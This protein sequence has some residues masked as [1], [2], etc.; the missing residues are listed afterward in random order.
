MNSIN[1][2]NSDNELITQTAH[3]SGVN[4]REITKLY[5]KLREKGLD[6][7]TII[8]NI[9]CEEIKDFGNIGISNPE[10][11][12]RLGISETDFPES[13]NINKYEE[14]QNDYNLN[15][16][17]Q[18]LTNYELGDMPVKEIKTV[19]NQVIKLYSKNELKTIIRANKNYRKYQR[20]LNKSIPKRILV[21]IDR[22]K[23]FFVKR[24][25]KFLSIAKGINEEITKSILD[26]YYYTWYAEKIGEM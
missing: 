26:E 17:I 12:K 22:V 1:W 13:I 15:S 5:N 3:N 21:K 16:E 2:N 19:N 4:R 11:R 14:M 10:L 7:K 8:E 9:E 6:A 24:Q 18:G 23:R 20:T 25:N